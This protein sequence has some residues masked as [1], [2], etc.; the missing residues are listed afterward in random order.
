[1]LNL[2][3]LHH[4]HYQSHLPYYH[5]IHMDAMG[6]IALRMLLLVAYAPVLR[7]RKPFFP[8]LIMSRPFML[9]S[10]HKEFGKHEWA[11]AM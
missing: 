7:A 5:P 11:Q 6:G 10:K 1:M 8:T 2:H 3:F 9:R 4:P